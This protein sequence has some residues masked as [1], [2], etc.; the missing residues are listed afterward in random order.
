MKIKYKISAAVLLT[1]CVFSTYAQNQNVYF[2]LLANYNITDHK[3]FTTPVVTKSDLKKGFGLTG[4]IGYNFEQVYSIE[5]GYSANPKLKNKS[6]STDL[7][8]DSSSISLLGKFNHSFGPESTGFIGGGL[9]YDKFT[10]PSGYTIKY[11]DKSYTVAANAEVKQV[12]PVVTV[13][14]LFPIGSTQL[15]V[16]GD[17]NFARKDVPGSM[18]VNF[19]IQNNF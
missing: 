9:S 4:Y 7:I 1:S 19:G 18:S 2:G 17:Y 14:M 6:T 11:D 16:A 5:L 15:A 13:G 12:V 3:E 8:S 10:S